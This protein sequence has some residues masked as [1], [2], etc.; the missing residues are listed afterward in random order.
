MKNGQTYLQQQAKKIKIRE[1]YLRGTP[2]YKMAKEHQVHRQTIYNWIEKEGWEEE[3][4][5]ITKQVIQNMDIS[6]IKEKERSLKL[7]HATESKYAEEL[8]TSQ[9][10]PKSV[11]AFA[12]IERVKWDI[13]APKTI[14]QYNFMKQDNQYGPTY[15]LE[16]IQPNDNKNEMDAKPEAVPSV[17]DTPRQEDN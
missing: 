9:G 11:S 1:E 8:R 2:I 15:S 5:K 7:I 10:M 3:K 16:I 4:E 14:A 6:L 12:Q 13:L 17:E